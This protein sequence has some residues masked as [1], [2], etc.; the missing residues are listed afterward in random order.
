MYESLPLPA[1]AVRTMVEDAIKHTPAEG[2]VILAD[3]ES[4][5]AKTL[6]A[7]YGA[8]YPFAT[9]WPWNPEVL[10]PEE[11]RLRFQSLTKGTLVILIQS[12]NFRLDAFRIR[13]ELFSR[14]LK[15]IEHVHLARMKTREE[16]TRYL[17]ACTY[18]P[19]YFTT[20]ANAL[21]EVLRNTQ[22]LEI[23]SVGGE[24]L[25]WKGE[26]EEPKLNTGEYSQ[27]KNIG[28]TFP[29]GEVFTEAKDLTCVDGEVRIFAFANDRFEMELFE[30]FTM[31]V[32]RGEVELQGNEPEAFQTI[33]KRIQETERCIVR[34]LGF[35][36][37][38][39]FGKQ[40]YVEDVTAFE[41]QRGVHLSLGEKHSV[42]PKAGLQKR[43][44]ARYHVDV[45]VDVERT[46]FY[47]A[48]LTPISIRNQ[49]I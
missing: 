9:I 14:G 10:R 30:P 49:Q 25:V 17:E 20:Q 16:Q 6:L 44:K 29:I 32:V 27:A 1:R 21:R 3:E 48:S 46:T 42:Y 47:D 28:G 12:T 15:T 23:L 36:L 13:I 41:R 22:A 40:A 34:E 7:A 31:R 39:A 35:G 37:N 18:G 2:M 11:M 8:A 19:T 33:V 5:L 43:D 24:K 45:F 26:L 4:L 38:P